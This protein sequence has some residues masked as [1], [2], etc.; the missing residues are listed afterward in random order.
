MFSTFRTFSY[1]AS[2]AL[3]RI[4]RLRT[5]KDTKKEVEYLVLRN[6]VNFEQLH[7]PIDAITTVHFVVKDLTG[8]RGTS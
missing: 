3:L 8:M 4:S 7:K 6:L 1:R 5:F 2:D